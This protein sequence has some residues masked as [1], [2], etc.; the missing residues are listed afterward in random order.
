M[1][2][3]HL[4]PATESLRRALPHRASLYARALVALAQVHLR[5]LDMCQAANAMA[6]A[7]A[8]TRMLSGSDCV[9]IMRVVAKLCQARGDRQKCVEAL[10][11]ICEIQDEEEPDPW[12]RA[13]GRAEFAVAEIDLGRNA[14]NRLRDALKVL[15][16]RS[17]SD[18]VV[19]DAARALA[20][21]PRKRLRCKCHPE[22]V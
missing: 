11:I 6:E 8:I 4:E 1:A 18:P 9:H 21:R 16:K 13:K 2:K 22:D 10:E 3:M 5:L 17:T 20:V 19:E 15:R 14:S 12:A 7:I